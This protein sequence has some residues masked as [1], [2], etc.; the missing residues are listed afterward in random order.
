MEDHGLSRVMRERTFPTPKDVEPRTRK[1]I[2]EARKKQDVEVGNILAQKR[3][4]CINE[5]AEVMTTA[6]YPPEN[7]RKKSRQEDFGKDQ[8]WFQSEH[9][10]INSWTC[11]KTLNV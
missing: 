9:V 2:E 1:A 11:L 6:N 7:Q 10:P 5:T 8:I 4:G 3:K